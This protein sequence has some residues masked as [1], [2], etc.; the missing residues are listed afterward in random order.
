MLFTLGN[1]RYPNTLTENQ[2]KRIPS[3]LLSIVSIIVQKLP[4]TRQVKLVPYGKGRISPPN[5]PNQMVT[6]FSWPFTLCSPASHHTKSPNNPTETTPQM[7][8]H[9]HHPS[10]R[11]SNASPG[12]SSA[13]WFARSCGRGFDRHHPCPTPKN[14]KEF[15][16]PFAPE[17][18]SALRN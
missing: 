3:H 13:P 18:G 14:R 12:A 9:P 1:L 5:F 6:G 10:V 15:L 7:L 11:R 8:A 4:S 17:R 16:L 2:S